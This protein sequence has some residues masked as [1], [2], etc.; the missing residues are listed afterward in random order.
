[1]STL[2]LVLSGPGAVPTS[3]ELFL[4]STVGMRHA[5]TE[6][7]SRLALRPGAYV[8]NATVKDLSGNRCAPTPYAFEVVAPNTDQLPFE[9]TQVVWVRFDTDREGRGKGD[10]VADFEQDLLSLGLAAPGDPLGRNAMVRQTVIDGILAESNRLLS[11]NPDGTPKA[12]SVALRLTTR[13]PCHSAHMQ[14]AVGGQD[15]EAP[16]RSYGEESTGILGR[17]L[18]DYRNATPNENNAGTSPGL[19]V[20][21]GELFL[22]EG[23]IFK[24]LYPSYVTSFGRTFRVLSPQMGGTPAGA[25]PLDS[26]VLATGFSYASATPEQRLRYDQVFGAA[27]ELATA[28]GIILAHE[29]GHSIGLVAEGEPPTGLHGDTSLHNSL[30]MLGDVMSA[31]VAWD[32]LVGVEHRFRDLNMAYLRQRVICK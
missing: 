17:A 18:F 31:Y 3:D 11:R 5:V 23:K 10:G 24:D 6:V 15:P 16:K 30:S 12:G 27:D 28:M 29:V 26:I 2:D 8:L 4:A 32:S 7:P 19:G 25:G 9:R 20:F 14:M 1:M 21:V 22:Y 13:M